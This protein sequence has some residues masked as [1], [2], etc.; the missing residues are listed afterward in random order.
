MP[1]S[2]ASRPWRRVCVFVF[3]KKGDKGVFSQCN[4]CWRARVGCRRRP[5]GTPTIRC[6]GSRLLTR[7]STTLRFGGSDFATLLSRSHPPGSFRRARPH[8]GQPS[9]EDPSIQEPQLSDKVT[10]RRFIFVRYFG[11]FL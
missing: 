7:G 2:G 10:R 5:E 8:A 11:K 3:K 9:V 1:F 6:G 4:R